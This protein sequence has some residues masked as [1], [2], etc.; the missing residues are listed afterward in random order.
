MPD[1][2]LTPNNSTEFNAGVATALV[3]RELCNQAAIARMQK[4]ITGD[5][6]S[7]GYLDFIDSL[8]IELYPF[9]KENEKREDEYS[10]FTQLKIDAEKNKPIDLENFQD[11]V[12]KFEVELRQFAKDIGLLMP[13]K[14]DPRWGGY[15]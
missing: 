7:L 11:Y 5:D 12:R 8:Y 4:R 6:E 9:M 13:G 15:A 3:I 10:K 2:E 14:R 1:E